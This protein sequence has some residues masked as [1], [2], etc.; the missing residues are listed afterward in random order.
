MY[1]YVFMYISICI[2]IH[3]C[4]FIYTYIC[5]W[6]YAQSVRQVGGQELSGQENSERIKRYDLLCKCFHLCAALRH[7]H[8]TAPH[9]N[10][11]QH[12]ATRSS[13][14]TSQALRSMCSTSGAQLGCRQEKWREKY[15]RARRAV[16]FKLY[17]EQ[18]RESK[19]HNQK[20]QET[21]IISPLARR[22][23][24]WETRLPVREET[25]IERQ[26]RE[27]RYT[28][29]ESKR[30]RERDLI[31]QTKRPDNID[32]DQETWCS[33]PGTLSVDSSLW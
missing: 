11:L 33:A 16:V 4:T 28:S 3:T 29:R 30:H 20:K 9:C 26:Q 7:M 1:I 23:S 12:T 25:P 15:G 31:T 10:T 21:H 17:T 32:K 24:H 18:K 19:R 5:I 27:T 22:D 14:E 2:Y 8:H 6:M 13:T